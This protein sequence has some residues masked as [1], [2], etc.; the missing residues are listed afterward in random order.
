MGKFYDTK[1]IVFFI[2]LPLDL[3]VL[4]IAQH[5]LYTHKIELVSLGS[6]GS[7]AAEFPQLSY[8]QTLTFLD[9]KI[10]PHYEK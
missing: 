10:N 3:L 2:Y 8:I 9:S 7:S 1:Q 4:H 6:H 5:F